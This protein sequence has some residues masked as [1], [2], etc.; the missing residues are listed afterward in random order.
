M[1]TGSMRSSLASAND[2]FW[3]VRGR[4]RG[5]HRDFAPSRPGPERRAGAHRV[6]RRADKHLHAPGVRPYMAALR[7]KWKFV[8]ISR[9]RVINNV[10]AELPLV[11]LG[12]VDQGRLFCLR[13]ER[14]F[15]HRTLQAAPTAGC[16]DTLSITTCVRAS[17]RPQVSRCNL[18]WPNV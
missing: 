3:T 14:R 2:P 13:L 17:S 5:A 8:P 4:R 9:G 15:A 18:A 16:H 10:A 7:K 11:A 1:R 12:L 6:A